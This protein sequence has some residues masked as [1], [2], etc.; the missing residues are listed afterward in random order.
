MNLNDLAGRTTTTSATQSTSTTP[1][2]ADELL[3]RYSQNSHLFTMQCQPVSR[4]DFYSE[5]DVHAEAESLHWKQR[6]GRMNFVVWA[7]IMMGSVRAIAADEVTR[8]AVGFESVIESEL[9]APRKK[10]QMASFFEPVR[11]KWSK[12]AHRVRKAARSFSG[13]TNADN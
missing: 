4:T 7:A 10:Y 2:P 12:M 6:L 8:P 1:V 5:G 3:S 9:R 13:Q 11:M